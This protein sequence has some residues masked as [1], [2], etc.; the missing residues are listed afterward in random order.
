MISTPNHSTNRTTPSLAVPQTQN[1]APVLEFNCLYTHDI[2]RKQKR[3]QDG[4]LRYHTFNKRVMVYDVPRNFIGD[5][6]WTG[7]MLQEG[8]EMTL[9]KDGVL[10][11]V[12][13][14]LGSTETDLTELRNSRKKAKISASSSPPMAIAPVRV[15]LSLAARPTPN[16]NVNH[17]TPMKHKS[18]NVLLGAQRGTSGKA[19]LPEISPFEQRRLNL[20]GEPWEQR[21]SPKRR[22]ISPDQQ[23]CS[24]SKQN[25]PGYARDVTRFSQSSPSDMFIH[26]GSANTTKQDRAL[27]DLTE[28]D[29]PQIRNAVVSLKDHTYATPTSPTRLS[30]KSHNTAGMPS[31]PPVCQTQQLPYKYAQQERQIQKPAP[32]HKV[33]GR[34]GHGIQQI[35]APSNNA[36]NSSPIDTPSNSSFGLAKHPTPQSTS[37][38]RQN[39][40]LRLAAKVPRKNILL[41]IDQLSRNRATQGSIKAA[42]TMLGTTGDVIPPQDGLI[43]EEE[44]LRRLFRRIDAKSTG[45]QV[46]IKPPKSAVKR[47]EILDAASA[48][49][50]TIVSKASLLNDRE[51]SR[52][53]RKPC[54]QEQCSKTDFIAE[55]PPVQQVL[56]SQM[57]ASDIQAIN[58]KKDLPERDLVAENCAPLAR[59]G[60]I[61]GVPIRLDPPSHKQPPPRAIAIA[62]NPQHESDMNK[63]PAIPR[64]P[65]PSIPQD[66]EVASESPLSNANITGTS[67]ARSRRLPSK[68]ISSPEQEVPNPTPEPLKS[69]GPWS[70]EAFDLLDWRPPSWDEQAWCVKDVAV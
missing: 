67:K 63:S 40:T 29:A 62:L 38:Q 1:T 42:D 21:R 13:D 6:H 37:P 61:A 22:R 60:R 15:P 54:R 69:G 27:I 56:G 59:V 64:P 23:D 30:G 2:R 11:Q 16:K 58:P 47:E 46:S 36:A 28:G 4:F 57:A 34:S 24:K 19:S 20:E 33:T 5:K 32:S 50:P 9:D 3:W 66:R 53:D 25:A 52:T 18:L 70:R 51:T 68:Y 45:K 49:T 14:G 35:F 44:R 43:T 7:G 65:K 10:V 55:Q 8:D 39:K 41:C 12:A 17:N 31:S 26:G 48:A